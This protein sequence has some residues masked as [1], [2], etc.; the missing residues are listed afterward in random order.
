MTCTQ[1]NVKV[2]E[3]FLFLK[4]VC[5]LFHFNYK[6]Y[7]NFCRSSN[8]ALGL[9]TWL[10]RVYKLRRHCLQQLFWG[11]WKGLFGYFRYPFR[12]FLQL[13]IDL[14]F[15]SLSGFLSENDKNTLS[16][17]TLSRTSSQSS[18]L[19]SIPSNFSQK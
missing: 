2:L 1:Y 5:V 10:T 11:I 9:C 8:K 12:Y 15:L 13:M 7:D 3:E 17:L 6:N 16:S 18:S 19:T 4:G 14:K